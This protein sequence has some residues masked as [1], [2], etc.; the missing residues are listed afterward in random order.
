[1]EARL[2][3]ELSLTAA[4]ATGQKGVYSHRRGRSPSTSS[5]PVVPEHCCSPIAST[6]VANESAASLLGSDSALLIKDKP[7]RMGR[8]LSRKRK[9]GSDETRPG[10]DVNDE[11]ERT[12]SRSQSGRGKRGFLW[13]ALDFFR[14]SR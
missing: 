1:M 9:K 8:V 12:M 4:A 11:P 5:L 2:H 14:T 13:G 10:T 6:V 3:L 7:P